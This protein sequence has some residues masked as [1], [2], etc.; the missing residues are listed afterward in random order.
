MTASHRIIIILIR[1]TGGD[2][3]SGFEVPGSIGR[4]LR[5]LLLLD[6]FRGEPLEFVLGD[7]KARL[8]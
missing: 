5:G 8:R 1:T 4:M 6:G 3:N 2:E 7:F